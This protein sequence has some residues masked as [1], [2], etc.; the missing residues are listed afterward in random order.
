MNDP[1]AARLRI[2]AQHLRL[3]AERIETMPAMSLSRHGGVDT[4]RG[5]RPLG[6]ERALAAMQHRVHLAADDLRSRAWRLVRR[7]DEL[8]RAARVATAVGVPR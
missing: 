1:N 7:A 5:P 4:W 6:C 8:D 3:L 2:R